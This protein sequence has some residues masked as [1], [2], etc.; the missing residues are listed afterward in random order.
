MLDIENK[1]LID[2]EFHPQRVLRYMIEWGQEHRKLMQSSQWY[3][4]GVEKKLTIQSPASSEQCPLEQ[5][6]SLHAL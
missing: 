5:V 6:I 1:I 3:C 4:S 2:L